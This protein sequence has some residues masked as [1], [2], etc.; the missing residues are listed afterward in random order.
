MMTSP[1]SPATIASITTSRA[2]GLAAA[3]IVSRMRSHA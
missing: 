3:A 1:A 2:P